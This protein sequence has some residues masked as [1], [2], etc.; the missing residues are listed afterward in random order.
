MDVKFIPVRITEANMP[1]TVTNGHIYFTVDT[2]K[3]YVDTADGRVS[4]GNVGV[5]ILYG[6]FPKDAEPDANTEKYYFNITDLVDK[7]AS[8]HVDDLVLNSDGRFYRISAVTETKLTCV[9]LS[10]SGTG[11]GSNIPSTAAK[12]TQLTIGDINQY[13]ING[14]TVKVPFTAEAEKDAWGAYTDAN[15]S[16]TWTLEEKLSTGAYLTYY[17]EVIPKVENGVPMELD[18]TGKLR[19]SATSRLTMIA[20]SKNGDLYDG[21]SP[22]RDIDLV[23]S[24]LTLS[25]STY[26]STT[27]TYP[28]NNV[29]IT[30]SVS[31]ELNKIVEIY[32]AKEEG[33]PTLVET[34]NLGKGTNIDLVCALNKKMTLSHGYYKIS[35]KVYQSI[36]G[37]K[38]LSIEPKEFEI[39][40]Y[41]DSEVP[42]IWLGEYKKEYYNYDDI[43]IPF[44]VYDPKNTDTTKVHFL[45]DGMPLPG[46]PRDEQGSNHSKFSTF[47]IINA[48]MNV[49]NYYSIYC[50]EE[51]D[52]RATRNIEFKVVQD[53][54]RNMQIETQGLK[55][56]FDAKGRTNSES[57]T[58]RVNWSYGDIT[59]RFENFNWYNNGWVQDD[60]GN[61][62][63]RISNGAKFI[64][65][66]GKST[67]G[68]AS[69]GKDSI[70]I[71]AQ[72]KVRNVQDYT[73][74][75]H[76][77]TRYV[78]DSNYYNA[79]KA[80]TQTTYSNYD[81][82]LTWY[83]PQLDPPVAYDKLEFEYVQKEINVAKAIATYIP[84]ESDTK[85]LCIGSQDAFFSNG[86]NTV[87]VSFVE[88]E[89]VYLS[90]V[91]T[92]SNDPANRLLMI[93]INGVLTGVIK[94]TLDDVVDI[95]SDE[96]IFNS[97]FCDIDLY[98]MRIYN[99]NLTINKVINN[100][101][102]D[103]KDVTIFDQNNVENGF[104]FD[105]SAIGELRLNFAGVEQYN[106]DNPDDY[107]MPYI[108]FD[109]SMNDSEDRAKLSWSKSNPV[110]AS[111]TF[112]NPALDRAY[113]TGELEELA[114]KD[115]LCKID[116]SIEVRQAAIREYYKHHC[117][118]W[119]GDGIEV[120]VQGT[121][122]EFYPRRNYKIKTKDDDDNINIFLNRGPYA[123]DYQK[124]GN[125]YS[126]DDAENPCHTEFWYMDNY[127][128]GTNKWTMK[129]DFMESSGS[130][131]TGFAN[132]VDNA[133]SKHPLKDY[134]NRI[135]DKNGAAYIGKNVTE[136]EWNTY[137]NSLRTSVKGF[138][139]MAFHKRANT[140]GRN[141]Y[142][143]IGRYNM[144]LDKGSDECFGFKP[145]KNMY[146]LDQNG[147][148][149]R[150]RDF[151]ECWEMQNNNHGYC[152][153]RDP[154]NREELSF[155]IWNEDG[156]ELSNA[157]TSWGSPLVADSFEYRYS[158]FDDALDGLWELSENVSVDKKNKIFESLGWIEESEDATYDFESDGKYYNYVDGERWGQSYEDL[159]KYYNTFTATNY[160][161]AQELFVKLLGNWEK[162][163]AWVW[164]TNLDNA[165]SG[166]SYSPAEVAKVIYTPDTYYVMSED[167]EGNAMY[168][169]D[170]YG[171]YQEGVVYYNQP[172][173][174][175]DGST[176]AENAWV[177]N[178]PDLVYASGKFYS[179]VEDT[180]ILET[181]AEFNETLEY[182]VFEELS[183]ARLDELIATGNPEVIKHTKKLAAPVTY[184]GI[185]FRY[186]T[187]EYRL[188]K[189]RN[190]LT[191]HFDRE[192]LATYFVMT[193]VFECYDSRGKNCMM[194]SWGPHVNG[195]DHI[196]Y[197][198]FYD[199]DTQLGI[200]NTGIP[201]FEYNVDATEDGN[202]STSD[203]ILWNNFY[204]C[205]KTT[206]ILEK[207][208]Q[209]RGEAIDTFDDIKTPILKSV[210][211]I[212][213][214]Y[215][216]DPVECNSLAMRGIRPLVA[217]NL[218]EYF[219]YLSIYNPA[220]TKS[221]VAVDNPIYGLTGRISDSGDYVVETTSYYYALQG[222]RSLSRRQF[223][224]NRIEYIDSWLNVGNYARGGYNRLW[225][226][227]SAR[228]PQGANSF[229]NSDRWYEV[230]TDDNTSYFLD[231]KAGEDGTVKRWDFDSEYWATLTP[232][233]DSY[234]TVQDDSAVYPSEKF[235]GTPVKMEFDLLKTGI[236]TGQDYNEQLCY[237]YGINQMKDL[238]DL[239]RMYWQEFK[240]EG[241]AGKLT[242]LNLGC[243]GLMTYKDIDG[244]YKVYVDENGDTPY[245][246]DPTK[247]AYKWFNNKMN[248]PSMPA[249]SEQTGMPLLKEANFCNIQIKENGPVLDL[250]SCEK[251]ENFR[252]TGS[253]FSQVK[254][255][256]GVALNTLYLPYTITSLQLNEARLLNNIVENYEYPERQTDGSYVM[257]NE[258]LFIEGIT[259]GDS[260]KALNL[261]T[262]GL[263]GDNMGY[264]SYKLLAKY[265]DRF[266]TDTKTVRKI[267]MTGVNWCPYVQLVEGD[268]YDSEAN[269][270][271]IANYGDS[272]YKKDNGHYGFEDYEFIN[273]S[274][275]EADILNGVVYKHNP[276][277]DEVSENITSTA[278][279]SELTRQHNT[280]IEGIAF[281]HNASVV[282][283]MDVNALNADDKYPKLK[284]FYGGEVNKA[285]SAKFVLP[286]ECVDAEH[287]VWTYEYVPVRESDELS[288]QKIAPEDYRNTE[289]IFNNPFALYKPEKQHH[290]FL[291]WSTDPEGKENLVSTPEAWSKIIIEE[292]NFDNVFYA[293]FKIKSYDITFYQ[294]DNTQ[295][296]VKG[297]Y[298]TLV[299]TPAQQPWIADTGLDLTQTY[300]FRGYTSI[301]PASG[302]YHVTEDDSI[303]Q[304]VTTEKVVGPEQ[305]YPVFTSMSVYDNIHEEYFIINNGKIIWNND[306]TVKGKLTIP[307][308]INGQSVT[309][310]NS[311]GFS[312]LQHPGLKDV[313]HIFWSDK[314]NKNGA[315]PSKNF[316]S[317]GIDPVLGGAYSFS[318]LTKLEFF[319]M[320]PTI[321][322]IPDYCFNGCS[323]LYRDYSDA[324]SLEYYID[325]LLKNVT[326]VG[327]RAFIGA[328][329]KDLNIPNNVQVIS[330]G[331]FKGL[332][333][334]TV[335]TITLGNGLDYDS[336]GTDLFGDMKNIVANIPQM[337][338]SSDW[339]AK[340]NF[341]ATVTINWI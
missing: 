182:Y 35:I 198:V 297:D 53:P 139:V 179:K 310:V 94:S 71:E 193:E 225:G 328:A 70:T 44:L 25:M 332:K 114:I 254:F 150:V 222:D 199:I 306:Y 129:I 273:T 189:F 321:N 245:G 184:D 227:I 67:I 110:S 19:E 137:R 288:I 62:C 17:T 202:Y 152:S 104:V 314:K 149:Q 177:T 92:H 2:G 269:A 41:D 275:F 322:Y 5:A 118:S 211:K 101:A 12:R 96:F 105:D 262:L 55:L 315:G 74:L 165:I 21:N 218:D 213:K 205:F 33:T 320:P 89:M 69:V 281:V 278:M 319:E 60:E 294:G 188:A 274:I 176:I 16:V 102:V 292:G 231:A 286:I 47:E 272:L 327:S 196:W 170:P 209:L 195:G 233:R 303:I 251:L 223:L 232:I 34:M 283:E 253:N 133:Y 335:K 247:K 333:S 271:H 61:T 206:Y 88:D 30:F 215:Q 73:P 153:F 52:R 43:K 48:E 3:I 341:D 29:P 191:K 134:E 216:C 97:E 166:G 161:P 11:D 50:G 109:T 329:I 324:A 255:A 167:A 90:A 112:V 204:K 103:K 84:S 117:P 264:D 39:A 284:L 267:T 77:I 313:T 186:D 138:P 276:E 163:C 190:E 38:G 325:D 207:Y 256:S 311:N 229:L 46:S 175:T 58:N 136:G 291:G 323:V 187:Q 125:A 20:H 240:I 78:G 40:V 54:N 36:N 287:N 1:E 113:V 340:F 159:Y 144:N 336:C 290:D 236:R 100:Y 228:R 201:S 252:A 326:N 208:K 128:V 145:D 178:N 330:T 318:N 317:L 302:T 65:P 42:I 111:I 244:T 79:F 120:V 130:Y 86:T 146:I 98:K 59:A 81:S 210:D 250:T 115:G 183:D 279:F 108:I 257:K 308:E 143:Y 13:L 124:Y 220:G 119:T 305:Y 296:V 91:Y 127:E 282:N 10:V 140:G 217:I 27:K 200:N 4:M 173:T 132:L 197:P 239:Y 219:K 224:T 31:G 339:I 147:N 334:N 82:F 68:S 9:L 309:G 51:E 277:L 293:I 261:H 37:E 260:S 156:T 298:N 312:A 93:Y 14:Q 83:L 154:W 270:T 148:P 45:K 15:V 157:R 57:A 131:N 259:D 49:R 285:Y 300:A 76:N 7:N 242:K 230:P 221:R 171:E 185:E 169:V 268:N 72:F 63:L 338:N 307:Y 141:D 212:E 301:E 258:G 6:D 32:A 99:T 142:V 266:K 162:A 331:G 80:E 160:K 158:A 107:T 28:V 203:S 116:D 237:I 135:V 246:D 106:E 316:I 121:S 174:D 194:A 337:Y 226:R 151:A 23:S 123:T 181:G 234:V 75:I 155:G 56:N 214:W 122:S 263:V 248:P 172:K 180:Y 249:G 243:D 164:S 299:R 95:G 18:L 26:F 235:S 64:L 280:K 289:N 22:S 85:G 192:Y 265:Y 8:P 295:V 241:E 238:G 168:I 126:T 66:I 24:D 304:E 87:N